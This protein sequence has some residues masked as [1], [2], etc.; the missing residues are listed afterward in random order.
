MANPSRLLVAGKTEVAG[1][2]AG[3]RTYRFCNVKTRQTRSF[4]ESTCTADL[5]KKHAAI[6]HL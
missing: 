4:L 1:F 3:F 5:F 2:A 6:I